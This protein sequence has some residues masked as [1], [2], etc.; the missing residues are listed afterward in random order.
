MLPFNTNEIYQQI[1]KNGDTYVNNS[2]VF[3]K[4]ALMPME[5][6]IHQ[7][8]IYRCDSCGK[9][10]KT[11]MGA[12]QHVCTIF[13]EKSLQEASQNKNSIAFENLLR[14]IAASD[15][16]Y[17]AIDNEFLRNSF[18]VFSE[19]FEIPSAD[20]IS[21]EMDGLAENIFHD[22]LHEIAGMSIS[23]L[24]DGIHRWYQDYQGIILFTPKQL[25]LYGIIKT[26][27]STASTIAN[28]VASI[29]DKLKHNGTSVISICCDNAKTNIK[30]FNGKEGSTQDLTQSHFVRQ[31]CM[32]HTSSLAISDIFSEGKIYDFVVHCIKYLLSNSPKKH[33]YG[34]TPELLTIRWESLLNCTKFINQNYNLYLEESSDNVLEALTSVEETIGWENLQKIFQIVWNFIKSIEKDL[35]SIDQIVLPFIRA[36]KSLFN[37]PIQ[38][39]HDMA[40][41]LESRFIK[42][43]PFQ[44]PLF[45][46]LVTRKGLNFYRKH[47]NENKDVVQNTL[48]AII[49]Y[50]N[51]RKKDD[52]DFFQDKTIY[53]NFLNDFDISYFNQFENAFEMWKYYEENYDQIDILLPLPFIKLAKEVLLI[54]ATEAAV[55]RLFSHLSILTSGNLCNTKE[56]TLNS[57]LIVKFDAIFKKAGSIKWTDIPNQSFNL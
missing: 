8:T 38:T 41:S 52:D 53:E 46:F 43:C 4:T 48:D 55:E 36:L 49:S 33:R 11:K 23:I 16:P 17:H 10:I 25:Y 39:A 54:P 2:G 13:L 57:R 3:F 5:D 26:D 28:E 32:A 34:R 31:S 7:S 51:E 29:I 9:I 50:Q 27:D 47:W 42:T 30:A 20:K 21:Y 1:F 45:A 37:M 22:M 35:T 44:L 56:K 14:Y 15:T 19:S 24:I 6:G 12:M 18:H 40:I